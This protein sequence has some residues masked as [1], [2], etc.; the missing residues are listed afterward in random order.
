MSKY[1]KFFAAF[2]GVIAILGDAAV[3]GVFT[4]GEWEAVGLAA[5]S[6]F[7]VWK[8]PNKTPEDDFAQRSIIQ[9]FR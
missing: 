9:N 8:L 4:S 7:F 2:A 6:A 1:A 5:V 3:D